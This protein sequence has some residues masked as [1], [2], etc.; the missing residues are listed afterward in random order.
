MNKQDAVCNLLKK[1]LENLLRHYS[2]FESGKIK[3]ID[4]NSKR[5]KK[6]SLSTYQIEDAMNEYASLEDKRIDLLVKANTLTKSPYREI[7]EEAKLKMLKSREPNLLNSDIEYV[8]L[9]YRFGVLAVD[10]S[11]LR[12]KLELYESIMEAEGLDREVKKSIPKAILSNSSEE[13]FINNILEELLVILSSDYLI[14]VNNVIGG[15]PEIYYENSNTNKKL[16]NLSDL[17]KLNI[18]LDK[19]NKIT[20]KF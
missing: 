10:Y 12:E 19:N 16:C 17:S 6:I 2:D 8:D 20:Y 7:I 11:K 4:L 15:S 1:T 5:H 18:Q 3:S 14:G 13:S 9:K